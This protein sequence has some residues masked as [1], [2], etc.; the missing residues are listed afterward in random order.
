MT[1]IFASPF[2]SDLSWYRIIIMPAQYGLKKKKRE[3][4]TAPSIMGVIPK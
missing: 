4:G 3:L 1:C 2:E